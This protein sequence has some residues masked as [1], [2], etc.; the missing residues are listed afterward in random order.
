MTKC[1]L[2]TNETRKL[3]IDLYISCEKDFQKGLEI[4]EVY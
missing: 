3:L 1:Y 2:L 4:F